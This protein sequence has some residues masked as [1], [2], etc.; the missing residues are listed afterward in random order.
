MSPRKSAAAALET[1]DAIVA[2]AVA[3]ASTDGLEGLTIGRL[4]GDLSMSK[5]GVIGHF[6]S[7]ER[8]QLAALEEAVGIFTRTV[9]EPVASRPAGRER[10]LAICDAWVAHLESGVFPGGCFLAAAA[11]EFDGR[12]G[13]VRD[14]VVAALGRWR[15]V[16]ERDVRAAVAAGELPADSDPAQVWFEWNA[17]AMG[18]NQALQLH[19]DASAPDRARRAMRRAIGVPG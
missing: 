4:A 15:A 16:I 17:F 2:R 12:E 13:P 9:W 18:L 11:A 5:A 1:R 6:G 3:V 19:G 8:L 7:K 10:L 14:G